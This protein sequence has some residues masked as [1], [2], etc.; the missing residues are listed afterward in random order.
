M[1]CDLP[2]LPVVFLLGIY[3][4]ALRV[5]VGRDLPD[6][7]VVTLLYSCVLPASAGH[8]LPDIPG[9]TLLY[10]YVLMC[11]RSECTT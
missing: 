4:C 11:V 3:L 1:L 10:N 7:P 6:I 2:N 8:D 5:S 9:V